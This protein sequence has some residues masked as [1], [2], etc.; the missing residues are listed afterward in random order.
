MRH[1]KISNTHDSQDFINLLFISLFYT[2]FS[3]C[4]GTEK[5]ERFHSNRSQQTCNCVNRA[6]SVCILLKI[7]DLHESLTFRSISFQ[8]ETFSIIILPY[9]NIFTEIFFIKMNSVL[10][11]PFSKKKKM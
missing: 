3:A 5:F 2:I 8:N 11:V 10:T 6:M 1:T 9:S 4:I 7:D